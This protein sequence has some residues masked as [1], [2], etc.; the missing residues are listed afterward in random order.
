[1]SRCSV[2]RVAVVA[3]VLAL[4][5]ASPATAL[6]AGT[7]DA[8]TVDSG[9]L[10]VDVTGAGAATE[11]GGVYY[12]WADEP[13]T[14]QVTVGDYLDDSDTYYADYD[15]RLTETREASYS[16]PFDT[17]LDVTTVTLGELATTDADLT[18][19]PREHEL[20][21]GRHTLYA[22]MYSS[23]S[24]DTERRDD[25]AITVH[26]VNKGG[27]LDADGLSN[28]NELSL[29]TDFQ[30]ADTDGD[31]LEDGYEVHQFDSDPAARDT[32]GDG[33]RDDDEIRE[34][35]DYGDAD[36]DADSLDDRSEL[37][38]NTSA[39]EADADLDGLPDPLEAELDTDDED[40]DTDGDG[41][42]DLTEYRDTGTDPLDADT[43]GDGVE[44]AI[45][46]RR[47]GSNPT[48]TDSDGD[49]IPDGEEVLRSTDPT[50]P[51]DDAENSAVAGSTG[52]FDWSIHYPLGRLLH[53]L[54]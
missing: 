52:A 39:I 3:V 44:D 35:T 4:V 26:V 29:G 5:A 38:G 6:A 2:P 47:Y 33:V 41:L 25:Q 37:A 14:V 10:S 51:N 13:A 40:R 7:T 53:A 22:T 15:V 42:T 31:E 24:G 17:S 34:G 28:A 54:T 12:V 32:D 30:D 45:E 36:T 20:E 9:V 48:A 19:E 18:L 43:D 1:M 23:Q 50:T 49:G 11:R 16:E 46:L 27:D 21:P 8:T